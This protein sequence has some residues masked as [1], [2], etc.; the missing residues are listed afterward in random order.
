MASKILVIDDDEE[1]AQLVCL[2]IERKGYEA[3]VAKNGLEGLRELHR[4]RPDLVILD[5]MMP[6]MD[7]WDVCQRIREISDVPIIFLTAKAETADK[8]MGLNL[9]ADDY[10][11]KPF[12]FSELVARVEAALRRAGGA[13]DWTPALFEDDGLVVDF[14]NHQVFRDGQN[15]KLSPTEFKVLACLLRNAGR[16]ATQDQLLSDVWGSEYSGALGYVK[17]YVRYLRQKLE[18]DPSRPKWIRTERGVGYKFVRS[19]SS[20]IGKATLKAPRASGRR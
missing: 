9:G 14:Q 7:G 6:E 3:I 1:I 4:E 11:T 17:L 5:V 15:V 12:E 10:M 2:W 13:A 18:R 20:G 8:I 16:V 19:S